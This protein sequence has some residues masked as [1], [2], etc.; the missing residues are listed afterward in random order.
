MV[1][2]VAKYK[3]KNKTFEVSVEFDEALK[4]QKG[5]GDITRALNAANI[6]YNAKEGSIA[7]QKDLMEAFQSSELY[8]IATMIIQKG[9]LQKPQE[10]RDAERENR[11]KQ[12]VTLLMRNAV[13]QHGRPYTED[14]LRKAIQEVHYNFDTR[15]AEKQMIDVLEKLKTIIPI[16]IDT[17]RIKIRIPARFSGQVYGLLKDFKESEEW[18]A[19][20]DLEAIVAIPAGMQLD[21]YDKLNGVTHGAVISEEIKG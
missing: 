13:D 11:I 3:V 17:K 5:I 2:V 10:F 8:S 20:G 9:E 21:F 19:N 15:P 14:R 18:L 4:V 12:V 16:R 7:S 1:V 6:F